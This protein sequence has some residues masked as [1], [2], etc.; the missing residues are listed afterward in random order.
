MN[1]KFLNVLKC[2]QKTLNNSKSFQIV[3]ILEYSRSFFKVIER[4]RRF[5]NATNYPKMFT[6]F[7]KVLVPEG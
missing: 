2:L 1:K 5:L 7:E 3:Q 4:S 6:E